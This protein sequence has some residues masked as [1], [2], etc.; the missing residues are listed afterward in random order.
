[1]TRT[2]ALST[3]LGLLILFSHLSA[4]SIEAKKVVRES[5][6]DVLSLNIE[7]DIYFS[8]RYYTNGLKL[9][10]TTSGDDWWASKLQFFVLKNLLDT[11]GAQFYQTASLGQMMYVPTDIETVNY[12]PDERPYCGWLYLSCAAHVATRDTL[13]SFGVSLG[14]VGPASLAEDAQKFW[15]SLIGA[16]WPMGWHDQ[17]KNEPGIIVTYKRS[18]RL[19]KFDMGGGAKSDFIGSAEVNLGNVQTNGEIRAIWRI[20]LN[21]PDSFD[22]NRIDNASSSDVSWFSGREKW[23]FYFYCGGAARFVGYDISLNGNTFADSR[24]VS[25]KWLVGEGMAGTSLRY[26]NFELN[27]NWTVRSAEYVSQKFSYEM[28]W[29]LAAKIYF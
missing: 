10:Y 15:H 27:L 6:P 25:P 18:Q 16:H 28:F 4:L 23:H 1:M 19:L 2:S 9:M 21:L 14:V 11:G 26:E 7:N 24:E 29:T 8:D 22:P 12:G 20:G 13:D 17:V 3:I 5:A